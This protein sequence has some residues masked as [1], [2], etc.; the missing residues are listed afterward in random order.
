MKYLLGIKV[1]GDFGL[2]VL[3]LEV[4]GF[5]I[6]ELDIGGLDVEGLDTEIVGIKDLAIW[7]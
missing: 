4:I 1:L 5:V 7:D 2:D 3:E 6:E